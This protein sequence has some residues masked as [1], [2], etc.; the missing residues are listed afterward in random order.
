MAGSK[1]SPASQKL[2]AKQTKC[3]HFSM[4]LLNKVIKPISLVDRID[5]LT[6]RPTDR[7]TDQ[8]T[9]RPVAGGL[10]A[11]PHH[12]G[13]DGGGLP[14]LLLHLH[15]GRPQQAAATPRRAQG[16]VHLLHPSSQWCQVTPGESNNNDTW[17][18]GPW[19]LVL[20]QLAPYTWQNNTSGTMTPGKSLDP[21]KYSLLLGIPAQWSGVRGPTRS[22]R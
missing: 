1:Q 7:P 19:H 13:V 18:L 11:G 16:R 3:S 2:D 12:A 21:P 10:L 8:S 9:D 6:N 20:P 15:P 17:E 4:I 14:R 22:A 5:Q